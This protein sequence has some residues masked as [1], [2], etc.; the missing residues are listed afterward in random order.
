MNYLSVS[1]HHNMVARRYVFSSEGC[2]THDPMN[3]S[4][5]YFM[6]L[7]KY[8]ISNLPLTNHNRQRKRISVQWN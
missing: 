6:E 5:Y 2:N 4:N 3:G 1:I 8:E 7:M